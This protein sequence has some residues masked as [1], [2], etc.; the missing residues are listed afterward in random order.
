MEKRN[1]NL[2]DLNCPAMTKIFCFATELEAT[3]ETFIAKS[4]KPQNDRFWCHFEEY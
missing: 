3:T 1:K 2:N 4:Q